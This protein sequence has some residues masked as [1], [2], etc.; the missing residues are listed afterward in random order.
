[1]SALGRKADFAERLKICL[2]LKGQEE[3]CLLYPE[4]RHKRTAAIF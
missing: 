2:M 4:S 1:M 3:K